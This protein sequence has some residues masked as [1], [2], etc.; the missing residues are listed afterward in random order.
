V[1]LESLMCPKSS[2]ASTTECLFCGIHAPI[3]NEASRDFED[4]YGYV[5]FR[6]WREEKE[7][8]RD[9]WTYLGPDCCKVKVDTDQ[10]CG[11]AVV[12]CVPMHSLPNMLTRFSFHDTCR[13]RQQATYTRYLEAMTPLSSN[14]A[15]VGNI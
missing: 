11:S 2:T 8:S 14:A 9:T 1:R 10:V 6:R 12:F 15:K 3:F 13:I 7:I 5:R 4:L